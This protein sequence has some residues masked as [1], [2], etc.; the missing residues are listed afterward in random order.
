MSEKIAI[1]PG[2][3]DPVTNGHIDLIERS[4]DIFDKVIVA[5]LVNS[6]KV[7]VFSKE[8]RVSM[9]KECCS[10]LDRVHV[11]SFEGLLVDY[12]KSQ[13]CNIVLRGLRAATDLE[14]EFQLASTNNLLDPGMDTVFLMPS[15]QYTFLTSS[16]VREAYRGGGKLPMCVPE[17]VHE[18]LVKK[19]HK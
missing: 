10:H 11:D 6:A 15:S 17:V 5:V 18:A 3:F 1:Y 8:E 2:T 4:L 16:M 7:P 13:N 12:L 14:Y 19:F 9:L